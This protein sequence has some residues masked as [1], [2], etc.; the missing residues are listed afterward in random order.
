M[1]LY[2]KNEKIAGFG[3]MPVIMEG[4][5]TTDATAKASDILKGKTAYVNDVKI[6]G[7]STFDADT[8]DATA[9]V[10]DILS[11]KTAY[12]NGQKHTVN[13]EETDTLGELKAHLAGYGVKTDVDENLYISYE[14]VKVDI[15]FSFIHKCALEFGGEL[16]E[17][18]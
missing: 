14:S 3:G 10:A 6:T 7:T 1:A 2:F 4:I 16:T 5:D 15:P 9:T 8:K 17:L 13:I 18:L 11:G 12:V